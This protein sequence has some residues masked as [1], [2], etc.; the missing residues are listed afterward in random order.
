[1]ML[2][3]PTI[4]LYNTSAVDDGWHQVAAPGGYEAWIV[5]CAD[6][7]GRS[8]FAAIIDG[9]PADPRYQAQF[10]RYMRC[11]TRTRPPL[12]R[13]FPAAELCLCV[14]GSIQWQ[15]T[16][17]FPPGTLAG[18]TERMDVRL[19]N[20]FV[21]GGQ[22]QDVQMYF[23]DEGR[24][25]EIRLSHADPQIVTVKLAMAE[26]EVHFTARGSF[27]HVF[28]ASVAANETFAGSLA[29]SGCRH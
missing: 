27:E 10:R 18:S 16:R 19:G 13:E 1:M 8:L 14:N 28:R 7:S 26:T 3:V 21:I 5:R 15:F 2:A 17:R 12:P 23:A 4:A 11:P 20:N 22:K 24:T 25:C 9:D 29:R 6:D